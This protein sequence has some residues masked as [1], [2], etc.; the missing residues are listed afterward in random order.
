MCLSREREWMCFVAL[1]QWWAGGSGWL[2]GGGVSL[3]LLA[4]DEKQLPSPLLFPALSS[5]YP[6]LSFSKTLLLPSALPGLTWSR[7]ATLPQ[8]QVVANTTEQAVT[9]QLPALSWNCYTLIRVFSTRPLPS[10]ADLS[11]DFTLNPPFPQLSLPFSSFRMALHLFLL[12]VFL[13]DRLRHTAIPSAVAVPSNL[14]FDPGTICL[15]AHQSLFV[16]IRDAFRVFLIL[17]MCLLVCLFHE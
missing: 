11:L 12:A 17:P 3:R 8:A 10:H 4:G 1:C 14:S 9:G 5:S 13:P 7:P 16:G 6:T 15:R 2:C